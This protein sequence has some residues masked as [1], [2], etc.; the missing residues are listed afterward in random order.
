M[1]GTFMTWQINDIDIHNNIVV[2]TPANAYAQFCVDDQ[3]VQSGGT[4]QL[5][6]SYGV[7][8]D[9]NVFHWTS[10]P[11]SSYP[12]PYI[13]PPTTIGVSTPVVYTTHAAMVSATSINPNGTEINPK[14]SGTSLPSPIDSSYVVKRA[15]AGLHTNA[16]A[17][18]P[19]IATLIG[20]TA[21]TKHAG[22]WRS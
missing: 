1:Y 5:L 4:N 21:G 22:A 17:L 2:D 6:A 12:Y 11:S 18:A 7:V 19:T 3:Q 20:Q 9:G 15:H 16:T 8:M 14:N 10:A 13:F